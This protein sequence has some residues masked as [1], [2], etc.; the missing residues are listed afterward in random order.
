MKI[1]EK[2]KNELPKYIYNV[3]SKNQEIAKAIMFSQ[4]IRDVFD[5]E[6]KDMDFEVS[7]KSET[8]QLRGR[9]D[10]V[11]GNI[12]FEF[13]KDL[14]S[15]LNKA[16]EE[17]TKYFQ[18][19]VEQSE[20]DFLGIANDGIHF[21][22]FYPVIEENKVIKIE[23]IDELNLDKDTDVEHIFLWFDSYLFSTKKIIPTSAD[24]KRRFGSDSPTFISTCKKLEVLFQK[25]ESSHKPSIIK[26]ESW[27]KYLEIVYGGKPD[28]RDLF[29]RH[30]Y[31]STLVKLLIHVKIT[32][33]IP[34]NFE[35]IMPI[36]FGNT[37]RNAGIMSFMEEDF[38]MWINAPTI[39]KQSSKIFHKLLMEIYVYDL[40]KINEDVL[41]ELY[42]ELV[43]PE[44]RR[45]L[46]EFYTPDWLAETMIKD[47][48]NKDV[49]KSI[50]DPAC[51]SGTFLFKTI[52]FKIELLSKK[53]WPKD[54]ILNH[55]LEN[56][57]GFDVHPL[58]VIISKTNYLLALKDVL[59]AK[60]GPISI[61]IYLSDSLK[62]PAERKDV[63]LS[64]PTFEF[65]AM[66]K[67]FHFPITVSGDIKKM[68]EIISIMQNNGR[69]Y[70]NY[71]E[72]AKLPKYHFDAKEFKRRTL[73]IF[74]NIALKGYTVA[75]SEI[76]TE[77]L[78]T[79][80]ELIEEDSDAIWPYV[81]RNMYKPIA[82]TQKQVD[83]IIGNPPWISQ[84]AMKNVRYK[85]Y[86]KIKSK[87]YGLI[88]KNKMHNI[89][90]MELASL[91]F[92]HCVDKYLTKNG[93]IGFVMPRSILDSSQHAQF[94]KFLKPEVRLDHIYDL[95]NVKPLFKIPSCV[96]IAQKNYQ[97]HYPVK[98]IKYDGTLPSNNEQCD[99]SDVK[100]IKSEDQYSPIQRIK[101][102]SPYHKLFSK[103]ADLIPRIFWFINIK[104]DSLLGFNP[105]NPHIISA[106]NKVVYKPWNKFQLEGN[107]SKEYLFNTVVAAGLLPFGILKRQL[108]FLPIVIK[109]K[110]IKIINFH[111]NIDLFNIDTMKYLK[112]VETLWN[113][114]SQQATKYTIYEYVNY[115]NKLTNQQ[116]DMKFK[117]IYVGSASYMTASVI[118]PNQKYSFDINGT[119]FITNNFITDVSMYY[120]DTND[121]DEAHYLTAI[122]NSNMLDKLIKPEQSKGS[123]GPRNIHKLPLTFNIPKFNPKISMHMQ[124]AKI[125]KKCSEKTKK[126]IPH[127]T[128]TSI[129]KLRSNVRENLK[130]EYC[131]IDKIV[132]RL[133]IN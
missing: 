115:R 114:N 14:N 66:G 9:I 11:F 53:Q 60:K 94:R 29:F 15:G 78:N 43:D 112:H 101:N 102:N 28:Q 77:S 51:G 8:M 80:Y 71:V 103:G 126:L 87:E 30:T 121:E 123:F 117:V 118:E 120:Y 133:D 21:K 95:K 68:D 109:N 19:Y 61:P 75:E 7:V 50:M 26:Y 35:E 38:F 89:P 81:L 4:F 108:L 20:S 1:L 41:K 69:E 104:T 99:I 129:G 17:L 107:V 128:I 90:N 42:Q 92:C 132:E 39:R 54:K 37:F 125:G 55:I 12:I 46:G 130:N 105:S 93:I 18:A 48:L 13:K 47:V 106:K 64:I 57:L 10:A 63:S 22:V 24:I 65:E 116:M 97:T 113:G 2:L 3:K 34:Q 83:I 23:E 33:G 91:F 122:L 86:L 16:K 59:H 79:L 96:I 124:L 98:L 56:V 74:K 111:D 52:Q 110:K 100:L 131:D 85:E 76:L 5:I 58:A 88:E 31:L 84:Q 45:S 82:I 70:E 72:K 73:S 40:D 62:I 44:I 6:L 27:S 32:K 119:A 127:F 36:L 67:K 49:T 25:A